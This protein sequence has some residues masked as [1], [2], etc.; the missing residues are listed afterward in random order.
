M[1]SQKKE[2]ILNEILFWK[3]NKLLP[4]HY[5]DFL[6]T[7]YSQGE[8]VKDQTR[9]EV[10]ATNSILAS[11]RNNWKILLSSIATAV[12]IITL[13]VLKAPFVLIPVILSISAIIGILIFIFKYTNN[14][15]IITTF[16]YATVALLILSVSIKFVN[17]FSD[18]KMSILYGVLVGNCLLWLIFGKLLNL[19]YFKISGV[20]GL[21]IIIFYMI[22]Y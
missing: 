16:S 19:I 14:K 9:L 1:N 4:E 3:K 13:F 20:V 11:T 17:L 5:C 10:S 7:L 8:E 6:I 12:L 21:L 18:V 22:F 15:T 2:V